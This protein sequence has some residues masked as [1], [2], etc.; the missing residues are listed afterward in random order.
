MNPTEGGDGD[1]KVR[2]P[3]RA[4]DAEIGKDGGKARGRFGRTGSPGRPSTTATQFSFACRCGRAIT[5][6][7][8]QA[9]STV[10]CGCG[11]KVGVPSLSRLRELSGKE[12]YES[13]IG[14]A[15]QRM[16]QTGE[17]PEGDIC[18]VSG[19]TTGDTIDLEILVPRAF[20]EGTSRRQ[21]ALL[22]F[23]LG[24]LALPLLVV[25]GRGGTMIDEEGAL[26]LRVP[27]RVAAPYHSK[28]RGM[29]QRRL[30]RLL[31]SVPVYATLLKENPLS[32]VSVAYGTP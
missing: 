29:S 26:T 24:F 5:V 25:R 19:K 2:N 6:S 27:L 22:I 9:G 21:N 18:A 1:G 14:D 7:P 32:R 31:C 15:I 11:E 20:R 8:S 17:V 23:L 30:R 4:P 13:G 10:R 12:A 28:V 3:Y 16:I